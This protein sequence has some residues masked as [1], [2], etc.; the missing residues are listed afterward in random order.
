MFRVGRSGD[1]S[2]YIKEKVYGCILFI[3]AQLNCYKTVCILI[4]LNINGILTLLGLLGNCRVKS[5]D[6]VADELPGLSVLQLIESEL[7]DELVG[8]F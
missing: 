7:A 1:I 8:I 2:Q 5:T 4:F 3:H 6:F